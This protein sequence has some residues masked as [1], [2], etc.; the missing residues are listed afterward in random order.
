MGSV[1]VALER[2][3]NDFKR[4]IALKRMHREGPRDKR[5]TEM[6]LR[7]ARL[8]RLLNHP[9]VVHAW[10]YGEVDGELYIA[11]EYVEGMT[12]SA[13]LEQAKQTEGGLDPAIVAWVLAEICDGLHAAHELRDETGRL[14]NVVHR[15]ISPHNVMIAFEGH[16]KLL[17]FGVAKM[18]A[19]GGLT[20]TGEVKGKAAYMSPE[21]A[22]GD[23]L[24]RR[25]D[26]Y[27]LGAVLF[28]CLAGRRMWGEGT[29]ME[30]LRK[31]A[32]EEPPPLE[33]A[34]PSAPPALANLHRRL[35]ARNVG[36]RPQ[37]A[38]TVA[39]ELRA[40]IAASE[41]RPDA[42]AV[43]TVMTRI[44][45]EQIQERRRSLNEAL[46]HA[47]PTRVQVLRQSLLSRDDESA[48]KLMAGAEDTLIDPRMP[49]DR[50]PM[51][52]TMLAG[53]AAAPA[54]RS[55]TAATNMT[56]Y[57]PPGVKNSSPWLMP[58][59]VVFVMGGAGVG[60]GLWWNNRSGSGPRPPPSAAAPTPSANPTASAT[61]TSTPTPTPT[62]A[63]AAA[64]SSNPTTITS[65]RGKPAA[66][67]RP[68][69]TSTTPQPTATSTQPAPAPTTTKPAP[70]P[71]D[72]NAI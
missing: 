55:A 38:A 71:V 15:D 61:P 62:A 26:L 10:D 19:E 9:N 40:F 59:I 64:A 56:S 12:L 57:T 50:P 43:R 51:L 8:A 47:A 30:T 14:L 29:D 24:D 3:A 1:E 4:I 44:F 52:P 32:L 16:V 5:H 66:T 27:A 53:P 54:T 70:K 65:A 58:V 39:D 22:M 41:A 45:G 20:K 63:A 68:H 2:G 72:T 49:S 23:P 13:V 11:M 6:F 31:L 46:H 36:D 67:A 28:E 48:R 18:D 17:D 21:Q 25:S 69:P 37:D 33:T 34:V 7:E 60:F 42:T 35:V